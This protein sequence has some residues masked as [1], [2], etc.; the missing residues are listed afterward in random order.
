MCLKFLRCRS[1]LNYPRTD[2]IVYFIY[3][4]WRISNNKGLRRVKFKA[5]P[6]KEE[7]VWLLDASQSSGALHTM[8]AAN[9]HPV[10]FAK[11]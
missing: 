2:M 4:V 1:A 3:G 6:A 10:R 8:D 5:M 7:F 11:V 9:L